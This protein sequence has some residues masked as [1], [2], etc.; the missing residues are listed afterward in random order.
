M[1]SVMA[2][3]HY[4]V[5]PLQVTHGGLLSQADVTLDDIRSLRR[6]RQPPEEGVM[7]DLLW[8]DPQDMVCACDLQDMHLL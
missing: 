3:V 5:V 2:Y 4:V 6:D 1:V 8:S 7:C